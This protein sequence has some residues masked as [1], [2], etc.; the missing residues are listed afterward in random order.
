[1][2]SAIREILDKHDMVKIKS[3]CASKDTSKKAKGQ[4]TERKKEFAS[5]MS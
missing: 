1:M 3:F 5:H 2:L 4:F